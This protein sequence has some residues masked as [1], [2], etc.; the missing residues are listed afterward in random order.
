MLA[1]WKTTAAAA[2]VGIALSLPA[3]ASADSFGISVGPGGGIGFSY[4]SGGYCDRWGCPDEFWDYPVSY[5]PVYFDGAWYRG[6]MYYRY[7]RGEYL[8]WVHGGWHEDDW[9]GDRP[10]WACIDQFGPALSFDW[11]NSHG[12]RWRDDWRQRWYRG[13]GGWDHNRDFGRRNSWD[14]RNSGGW[15]RR[16]FDGDRDGRRSWND[17]FRRNSQ[18]NDG[19]NH[20]AGG[21][22]DG[23]HFWNRDTQT[24]G[25]GQD[26]HRAFGGSPALTQTPD[27]G[28]HASS[29]F[30]P[31]AAMFN[32]PS[33]NS[34][35]G[36]GVHS[37]SGRGGDSAPRGDVRAFTG[38]PRADGGGRGDND[39]H[40]GDGDS[41][42][43]WQR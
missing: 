18:N 43:R 40:R 9:D 34:W 23:R 28:V 37:W 1:M 12:F 41:H 36:G 7:I 39:G 27:P 21:W 22:N 8:F 19:D 26:W 6:P 33:G 13:H 16:S 24:G 2:L 32:A 4:G 11:Y 29:R 5:C 38:S 25:S 3:P 35:Q 14:N 17:S 10:D 42:G 15:D 20:S 30:V 31:P